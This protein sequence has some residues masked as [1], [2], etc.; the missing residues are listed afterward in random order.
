MAFEALSTETTWVSSLTVDYHYAYINNLPIKEA[1]RKFQSPQ[2]RR[3][4]N[5]ASLSELG[6]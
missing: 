3:C 5:Y 2:G 1:D 6:L 4:D